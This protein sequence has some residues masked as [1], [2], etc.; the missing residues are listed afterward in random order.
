MPIKSTTAAAAFDAEAIGI[1]E[2]LALEAGRVVMDVYASEITFDEKADLSPVTAADHASERLILAG[3]RSAL[4]GIPCV[5]EEEIAAGAVPAA[6]G[7]EFI[8]VDPLDG[9][10]EFVNRR[11]DF[12]VNIALI[13]KGVPVAGVVYAPAR[14]E[15]HS[16]HAKLAEA[17]R[18]SPYSTIEE[19]RPVHVRTGFTPLTIVASR[20]H[21]NDSTDLYI[22]KFSAAEIVSVGSSLKFC[23]IASGQADLYPRFSRTMEWDTAAGDA[24]LRAAGGITVT[25]DGKPLVYGKRGRP[26][27]DDFA[28]P[29][30][31]A[32][33]RIESDSC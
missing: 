15:M 2:R 8:L 12:T 21:R 20:S 26:G 13:R 9:T 19:R 1:F 16:G 18:V 6:L 33:G 23:M 30:F 7:A 28:N 11:P 5:A 22:R 29:D 3:L 31:I 4:P 27:L 24:V 32:K 10:R 25:L 17:M 14:G